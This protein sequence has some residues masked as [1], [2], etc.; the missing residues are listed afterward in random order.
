[1]YRDAPHFVIKDNLQ[2]SATTGVFFSDLVTPEV[3]GSVCNIITGQP[4][5]T[6]QYVDNSYDNKTVITF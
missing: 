1:M 4:D 5:F 3:L 6:C 2:K